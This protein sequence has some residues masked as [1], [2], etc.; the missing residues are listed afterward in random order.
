MKKIVAI[1]SVLLMISLLEG[2]SNEYGKT[3][4]VSDKEIV[5]VE[6]D[7]EGAEKIDKA[8]EEEKPTENVNDAVTNDTE[9]I[10]PVR[11][12]A[13]TYSDIIGE[14]GE[15]SRFDVYDINQD[16]TKELL[17]AENDSH[18]DGI[19]IISVNPKTGEKYIIGSFGSYGNMSYIYNNYEIISS[20]FGMGEFTSN[21]YKIYGN[22]LE[23]V[24]SLFDNEGAVVEE[25]DEAEYKIDDKRVSKDEY[26]KAYKEYCE[27]EY[28][29]DIGYK[30][31]IDAAKC[32]NLA[33]TIE[34]MLINQGVVDELVEN[35]NEKALLIE[36]IN[37]SLNLNI[38]KSNGVYEDY[39]NDGNKELFVSYPDRKENVIKT[40][41]SNGSDIEEME[42]RLVGDLSKADEDIFMIET[43]LDIDNTKV[44][45]I[46]TRDN[47]KRGQAVYTVWDGK[48]T[49]LIPEE[50]QNKNDGTSLV[51]DL[52]DLQSA[53]EGYQDIKIYKKNDSVGKKIELSKS[54]TP[55]IYKDGKLYQVE[56]KE[57]PISSALSDNKL[58]KILPEVKDE[59]VDT[60]RIGAGLDNDYEKTEIEIDGRDMEIKNILYNDT[61]YYIINYICK[62]SSPKSWIEEGYEYI[63]MYAKIDTTKGV[64]RL[65]EV[66]G[67]NIGTSFEGF[68]II[69]INK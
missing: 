18:A 53:L 34:D 29:T 27:S 69:E 64:Y 17:L 48:A 6:S 22:K 32:E 52:Y 56:S 7:N 3:D 47:K 28:M 44:Y 13:L 10:S 1:L 31:L 42:S 8:V 26:D 19:N 66:E 12:L 9:I 68:D 24:I 46:L 20:Y 21:V 58:K 33:D 55:A 60:R 14:Y 30:Y 4:A 36:K 23:T 2:C 65:I 35:L 15:K 59:I 49:G 43:V 25:S 11:Q 40:L 50:L 5:N 61:G 63:E 51:I 16:G 37:D 41:Y 45:R 67:G 54:C 39:D 38:L 62:L 57:I